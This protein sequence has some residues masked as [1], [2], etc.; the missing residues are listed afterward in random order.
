[1][2]LAERCSRID[3]SGIRK[4]FNLAAHMK[5]PCNLSIG[6]PDF[7]VP[8]AVKEVAIAGIRGGKNRYTLTAGNPPLREKILARYRDRGVAAPDVIVTSGTTGGLL[9]TFLALLDPGDEVLVPDPYFVMYKHLTNFIGAKP[10]YVD[11]Y[12]NFKLTRAALEA[13]VSPRTK[14]LVLNSPNNPTGAVFSKD[15]L[16][17]VVE[18]A[19]AHDLWIISDEIYDAFVFDGEFTHTGALYE[20]TLT[21]S[22]L[23]KTVGMTGWRVGWLTGPSDFIAACSNIQMYTFVCAPSFAQEAAMVALDQDLGRV[24][25]EYRRKRDLIE[26]G[27]RGAGYEVEK[28]GGAFYI[29][30]KAPGG[31]GDAFV[32]KAIERELLVVPG[33]VFSE[34]ATHFRISYASTEA[35]L[36]RAISLLTELRKL[37]P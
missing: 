36:N 14:L 35:T 23:S 29:F 6:Q 19:R 8:E 26:G 24:R 32:Q 33:S 7:D 30:P 16:R 13:K 9:L 1:M 3:S 34:K 4:V 31:N 2:K 27:L 25:D 17:E 18:F 28:P 10:V 22:G 21:I 20:K 12:P 15:D 37:Y 5:N 11:T